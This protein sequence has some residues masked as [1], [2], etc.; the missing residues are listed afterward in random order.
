MP[1]ML[2]WFLGYTGILMI[3]SPNCFCDPDLLYFECAVELM[4]RN[5][6]A[7]MKNFAVS[8]MNYRF[9]D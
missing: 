8:L 1:H 2:S 9:V 4:G 6:L 3:G 5:I 7:Y